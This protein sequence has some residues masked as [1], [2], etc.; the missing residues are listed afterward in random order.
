M[1]REATLNGLSSGY[2]PELSELT[3]IDEAAISVWREQWV[4]V[5]PPGFEWSDW[6]W[7]AEM[8]RWAGVRRQGSRIKPL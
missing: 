6:D 4:P 7:D 5:M 1:A 8:K 3:P 2:A